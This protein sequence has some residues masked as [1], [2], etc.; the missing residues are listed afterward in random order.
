MTDTKRPA[1][2]FEFVNNESSAQDL[3]NEYF[4]D[5]TPINNDSYISHASHMEKFF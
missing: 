1:N 2:S 4:P 3:I 5:E